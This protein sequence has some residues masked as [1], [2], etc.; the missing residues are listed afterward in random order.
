MSD[1]SGTAAVLSYMPFVW[2][3]QAF[4]ARRTFLSVAI[5]HMRIVAFILRI[6]YAMIVV[7]LTAG[8]VALDEKQCVRSTGGDI[9]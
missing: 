3:I 1:H 5:D 8:Q 2:C 4:L 6:F 7:S 9:A